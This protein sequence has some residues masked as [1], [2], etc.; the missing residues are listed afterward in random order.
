MMLEILVRASVE[1][2]LLAATIWALCRFHRRLAPA[3]RTALWWCV[4]AKFVVALFWTAP[5]NV[6]VLPA[7]ASIHE[8]PMAVTAPP[9][10]VGDAG[11][12]RPG[13]VPEPAGPNA[14]WA[15][16]L[17]TSWLT[18][19][20]VAGGIGVRR[21]KQMAGVISRS[22]P[23]TPGIAAM[24]AELA[25]LLDLRRAP[26]V[27]LSAEVATPLV[28]GILRPLIL[29]PAGPFDALSQ[30]ERRLVLCHEL[31]HVKRGDLWLGCLPAVAERVFFFHP[32]AHVAAREYALCREAACD[33][34]VLEVL[35]AAP[36]EYGR[37]LLGLGVSRPR[38]SLAVAGAPWSFSTLSRRIAMLDSPTTR[39]T[40]SRVAAA[41]VIGMVALAIAPLRI[42]ARPAAVD[43]VMDAAAPTRPADVPG[44]ALDSTGARID[45]VDTLEVRV[46]QRERDLNYVLFLDDERTTMSGSTQDINSA[47]RYR[48]GRE[49]MLW[50][51]HG[52]HEYV[53]RDP[54][55]LDQVVD[56][57]KS[58]SEIGDQQGAL[59]TRQGELGTEQG[60]LGTRQGEL[61]TQQGI[62][63]TRQGQL[64][65][66]QGTMAAR[67]PS[68]RT[69]AERDAFEQERRR[70]DREMRELDREMR[71]LNAKMREFDK[72]MRD[73]GA[74]MEVLGK[75]ME[76]LGRKMEEE[77]RKAESALRALFDR[78]IGTGAA[79]IVQ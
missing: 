7:A 48:R 24:A 3:T 11:S 55:I 45:S 8:A 37:L 38:T 77:V 39:S 70:I 64:G 65:T 13:D 49:R 46:A 75:E 22:A 4:S 18:G 27:R 67:E 40:G 5:V 66:M 14:G 28:T 33:A 57:W 43:A 6:P 50:F 41:A 25:S 21:W 73:L 12:R 15:L 74:Q 59:G 31:T 36:Q 71:A 1:G 68:I 29:L 20:V 79:E 32:L 58:V 78:A 30:R 52:S 69:E 63:G 51:R 17:V 54:A 2:A 26:R 34:H 47:R 53:I 19:V 9:A 16:A 72:P 44:T 35:G 62:L 23:S 76:V 56:L 60:V 10:V 61:G 42:A